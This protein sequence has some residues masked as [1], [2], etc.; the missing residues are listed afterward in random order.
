MENQTYTTDLDL[1]TGSVHVTL[2]DAEMVEWVKTN[3]H[4]PLVADLLR[5]IDQHGA[6][7]VAIALGVASCI[8]MWRR[9]HPEQWAARMQSLRPHHGPERPGERA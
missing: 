7:Q 5:M 3:V 6:Q 2:S 4:G 9:K 1:P 8:D